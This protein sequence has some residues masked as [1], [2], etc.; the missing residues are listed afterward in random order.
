MNVTAPTTHSPR[1]PAPCAPAARPVPPPPPFPSLSDQNAAMRSAMAE[2][3]DMLRRGIRNDDLQA[4]DY[5]EMILDSCLAE[6][7][8]GAP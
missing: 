7:D 8:V 5:A 2:A 1:Q 4:L 6:V 3:L